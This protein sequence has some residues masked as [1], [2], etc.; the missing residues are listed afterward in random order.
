MTDFKE[1]P[2]YSYIKFP[3]KPDKTAVET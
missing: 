3:P 2:M 1:Q